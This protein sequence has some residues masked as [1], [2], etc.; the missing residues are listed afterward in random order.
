MGCDIHLHQE[1]KIDG[2]WH[3]YGMPHVD[4]NYELFTKLAGV[5]NYYEREG[6]RIVPF[7][8]PR[9]I[10]KDATELTKCDYK[11]WGS[12]G[13]SHS[14]IT[15]E[16]IAKLE[17]WV[18]KDRKWEGKHGPMWWMEDTFGYLFGNSWA[19]FVKYPS[20]RPKGLEDVRFVFWFDC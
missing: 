18:E 1:V 6:K 16:E 2:V 20:D 14:F 12:D 5:R 8:K 3:H 15:A 19:G 17:D 4:R 9:G 13:H 7:A 11:R 10:P